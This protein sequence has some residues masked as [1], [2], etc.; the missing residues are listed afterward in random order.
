NNKILL[1]L[2]RYTLEIENECARLEMETQSK[3]ESK[4]V[5][6]VSLT[7]NVTTI[8]GIEL[9]KKVKTINNSSEAQKKVLAFFGG[10]SFTSY[11]GVV[12]GRVFMVSGLTLDEKRVTDAIEALKNMNDSLNNLPEFAS[13]RKQMPRNAVSMW[14]L[15]INKWISIAK[16]HAKKEV[17]SAP[18]T[19]AVPPMLWSVGTTSN[20][21]AQELYIPMETL[22]SSYKDLQDFDVV[23][24]LNT[25]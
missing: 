2:D 5:G 15:P 10:N 1:N 8:N 22:I 3:D 6:K 7:E 20:S 14:Y 18:L 21:I 9:M 11:S 12:A 23:E 13:V 16:S 24:L 25:L 19:R 4:V 17:K